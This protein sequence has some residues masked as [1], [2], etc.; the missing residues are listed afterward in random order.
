MYGNLC[1]CCVDLQ[2]E[3]FSYELLGDSFDSIL[4]WDTSFDGPRPVVLLV[5][6]SNGSDEF[7]KSVAQRL[8]N[9]GFAAVVVG[10]F[11]SAAEAGAIQTEEI[12]RWLLIS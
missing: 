9:L 4:I 3:I 6:D 12:C 11:T 2:E 1:I 10:L 5:P 7:E 8:S